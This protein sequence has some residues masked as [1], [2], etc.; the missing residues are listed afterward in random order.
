MCCIMTSNLS[1][2]VFRSSD[3]HLSFVLVATSTSGGR[4]SATG[5]R[6]TFNSLQLVWLLYVLFIVYILKF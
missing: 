1:G 6:S 3:L 5:R 4:Y 2:C